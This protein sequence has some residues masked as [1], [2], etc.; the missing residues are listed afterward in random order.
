MVF[1]VLIN[2]CVACLNWVWSCDMFG[3]QVFGRLCAIFPGSCAVR[4]H[5]MVVIEGSCDESRDRSCDRFPQS[6]VLEITWLE[7]GLGQAPNHPSG[8][9]MPNPSVAVCSQSERFRVMPNV[10][11]LTNF[12]FVQPAQMAGTKCQPQAWDTLVNTRRTQTSSQN[13]V[14]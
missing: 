10:L 9:V 2:R 5:D 7:L 12:S 4:S 3:D 8:Q 14:T 13:S 1:Q 6:H 11:M